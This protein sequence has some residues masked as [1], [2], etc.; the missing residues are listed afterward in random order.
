MSRTFPLIGELVKRVDGEERTMGIPEVGKSMVDLTL[1]LMAAPGTTPRRKRCRIKGR[2]TF[3]V[4]RA[5]VA[6]RHIRGPAAKG[7]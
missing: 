6:P 4:I 2:V 3:S 7:K 1:P 5:R